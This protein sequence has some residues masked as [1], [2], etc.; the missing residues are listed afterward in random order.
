MIR[1]ILGALSLCVSST[2]LAAGSV[3]AK[4]IQVRIDQDGKGMVIFDRPIGG[5]PPSCVIAAYANALAF[6]NTPAGR[7]VM[8]MALTAKSTGN[9]VTA[10]GLGTCAVF[11]SYAEDWNYG[12][13]Q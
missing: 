8:A 2:S 1:I 5:T 12:V 7:A 11:G 10:Y 3:D 4:V 9:T 13:V 6:G